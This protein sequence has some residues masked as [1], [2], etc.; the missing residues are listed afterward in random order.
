VIAAYNWGHNR[1]R[2][3]I[4]EMPENPRERNFWTLLQHYQIPAETYEYVL[5]IFAA[6]VIGENPELFGF[7]FK[8]P[9][10]EVS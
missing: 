5:Y 8:N 2:G 3:L 10:A 7:G 6:A 9:L 1:V 4:Q